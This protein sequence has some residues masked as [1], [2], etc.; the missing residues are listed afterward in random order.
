VGSIPASYTALTRLENL[1][2][3]VRTR[4]T[5]SAR[6]RHVRRHVRGTLRRAGHPRGAGLLTCRARAGGWTPISCPVQSRNC[7][8]QAPFP[9]ARSLLMDNNLS[10]TLPAGLGSLT[11]LNYLCEASSAF[12]CACGVPLC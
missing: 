12:A 10:S 1:C 5:R 6:E 7:K 3:R 8:Q 2:V 11:A 4:T 9:R